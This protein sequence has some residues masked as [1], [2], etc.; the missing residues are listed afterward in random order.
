MTL[1]VHKAIPRAKQ[2]NSMVVAAAEVQMP[3]QFRRRLKSLP[4][5]PPICLTLPL[6]L[7]CKYEVCC[8]LVRWAT[9]AQRWCPAQ[10]A[11]WPGCC[12]GAWLHAMTVR[13]AWR[14]ALPPR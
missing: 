11:A 5:A 4:D 9:G 3:G 6:D 8:W 13:H 2:G 7:S 10:A 14:C 12:C 1:Q